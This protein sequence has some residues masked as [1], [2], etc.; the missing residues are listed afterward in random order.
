MP[1]NFADFQK[2]LRRAPRVADSVAI[3]VRRE[4]AAIAYLTMTK[5]MPVDTGL[6]RGNTQIT[7]NAPAKRVLDRLATG[8]A[9]TASPTDAAYLE[10]ELLKFGR[11]LDPYAN[12]HVGSSVEY[13]S[14]VN[15]G[16]DR[17]AGYHFVEITQ[18]RLATIR[19]TESDLGFAPGRDIASQIGETG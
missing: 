4:V 17:F 19:L 7:V 16:T 12:V 8:T 2:T 14:Y 5:Y 9:G 6:L 13:G 3:R 18:D 15:D 10:E 11:G 1:T